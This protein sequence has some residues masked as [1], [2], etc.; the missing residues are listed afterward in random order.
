[1]MYKVKGKLEVEYSAVVDAAEAAEAEE[2][3]TAAYRRLLEDS[4][5][6]KGRPYDV[7]VKPVS[8]ADSSLG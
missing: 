2:R 1:M 8:Q 7:D 6:V 3:V 5:K 4:V